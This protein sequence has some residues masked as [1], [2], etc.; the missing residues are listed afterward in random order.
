MGNTMKKKLLG[1][2]AALCFASTSANAQ[3]LGGIFADDIFT[4]AT[5]VA[6]DLMDTLVP[7][8]TNVRLGL[9]PVLST[10]YEGGN[11]YNVK[12]APLISLRYKDILQ[13]DN[14]QLRINLFGDSGTMWESTHFRAGP[15]LKIDFGRSESDSIDLTGMGNVGTSFELGGFMSYTV[16]PLRYRVRVRHDVASGHNGTLAD[17]DVSLAVFR[18]E[19]M[20]V[21]SRL[22]TTWANS[23]YMNTY[24][25][26]DAAQATATGLAAYA[27]T[28]GVK[29]ISLSIGSELRVTPSW[30]VVMN[31][32]VQRLL[33]KAKNSPLVTDRGSANQFSLGAYAV[34]SF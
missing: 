1:A 7:G 18:S 25:G 31:G 17:F 5:D 19:S 26:I 12:A 6:S 2:V 15:L 27:P 30:A 29:D 33:G 11:N 3:N 20:T 34:Y 9:G 13:V 10:D 23:S 16:G 4:D 24:F 14:N 32:G 22:G 28:S 21:G 8:V